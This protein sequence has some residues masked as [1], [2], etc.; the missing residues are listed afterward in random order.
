MLPKSFMQETNKPQNYQKA[1]DFLENV[2]LETQMKGRDGDAH[3]AAVQYV[4]ALFNEW[5]AL[6]REVADLKKKIEEMAKQDA[7]SSIIAP[8]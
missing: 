2:R 3:R 4:V 6:A 5:T 1:I 7:A 8:G